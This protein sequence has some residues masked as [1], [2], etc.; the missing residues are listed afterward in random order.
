[1]NKI[2]I[3]IN[4]FYFDKLLKK[5][6]VFYQIVDDKIYLSDSYSIAILNRDEFVL[7]INLL[8]ETNLDKFINNIDID[9]YINIIDFKQNRDKTYTLYGNNIVELIDKK[10]LKLFESLKD[11]RIKTDLSPI[12]FY[13]KELR[14][15]V[16]PIKVY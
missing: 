2:A 13:D 15:F 1:M 14:G 11:I 5:E 4:K 6:K 12:L 10:Y 8:N 7:N 16:L 3:N 9:S